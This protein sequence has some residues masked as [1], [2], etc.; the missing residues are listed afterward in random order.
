MVWAEATAKRDKKY[1]SIGILMG[2]ILELWRYQSH[3]V[4]SRAAV[5]WSRD[6]HGNDIDLKFI[7]NIPNS[8]SEGFM[9]R[10]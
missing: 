9:I 3:T 5:V 6:I 4:N 8:S 1:L 2:L 7:G 10:N